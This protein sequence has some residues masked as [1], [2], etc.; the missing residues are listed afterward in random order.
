M[1]G[2]VLEVAVT[3]RFT[4]GGLESFRLEVAFRAAAGITVL[5]GPSGGGKTTLLKVIAGIVRP[6][7]GRIT[8]GDRA[9]FDSEKDIDL[10]ISKRHVG[11]VFQSP[12]LFP[13]LTVE[14][15]VAYG[16]RARDRRRRRER[17]QEWLALLGI[18]HL[19]DRHPLSLSGGEQQRVALARALASEPQLLLLDEPLSAVDVPTRARLLEEILLLHECTRLPFLYVTHS[20]GEAVRVGD[21]VILLCRGRIQNQGPAAEV[22]RG[23]LQAAEGQLLLGENLFIAEIVA[24]RPQEGMTTVRIRGCFLEIPYS[25]LPIGCRVVLSIRSDGILVSRTAITKTSARNILQGIVTRIAPDTGA[26]ELAVGGDL[27]FTVRVTQSAVHELDLRP[28][29]PVYL[30]IKA[31]ACNL[32]L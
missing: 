30:L 9:F 10:P 22:L 6:C 5:F 15:N 14:E 7:R 13:H 8:F 16:V 26:V 24:H 4:S 2:E 29:V 20:I 21:E 11:M 23:W 1:S 18:A 31:T 12:S 19:R 3:K 28:G 27:A 25:S 32:L 17:A